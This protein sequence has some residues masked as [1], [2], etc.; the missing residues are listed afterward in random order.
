MRLDAAHAGW[1]A[2]T[3]GSLLLGAIAVT[4]RGGGGGPEAPA[5]RLVVSLPDWL[6]TVSS[7]AGALAILLFVA[8]VSAVARRRRKL[9]TGRSGLVGSVL[10]PLVIALVLASNPGFLEQLHVADPVRPTTSAPADDVGRSRELPA[11]FVPIFTAAVGVLALAGALGSLALLCWL[12]FGTRIGRWWSAA[13]LAARSPLAE[14][15]DESL[16]DLRQEPDARSAIIHCYGRFERVLAR[17]S[18]PRRPWQTSSE[19]MREALGRLPVPPEAVRQLTWLFEVARFSEEPLGARDRGAAWE[20]LSAIRAS[21]EP[22]E[23]G[24]AP[25]VAREGH[26]G[27]R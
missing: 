14:A 19:L 15:V 5:S 8:F 21:L 24:T 27:E 4:S 10:V 3:L 2:L 25:V 26:A 12:I 20:A 9:E 7:T 6:T 22:G 17:S 11:V 13:L 1:T 18:L 16:E 23:P